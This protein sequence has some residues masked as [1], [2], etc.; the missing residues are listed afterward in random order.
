MVY[1]K[2][3]FITLIVVALAIAV[4]AILVDEELK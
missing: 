1:L 2:I 3:F 4:S